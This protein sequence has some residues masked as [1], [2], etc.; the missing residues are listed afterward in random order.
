[1]KGSPK[2]D[3][4]VTL[5]TEFT[6]EKP[7]KKD[8]RWEGKTEDGEYV[9]VNKGKLKIDKSAKPGDKIT[10]TCTSSFNSEPVSDTYTVIVE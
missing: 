10:V 7:V 8:L 3:K 5:T 1:M 2:P 6:P 9:F 4:T